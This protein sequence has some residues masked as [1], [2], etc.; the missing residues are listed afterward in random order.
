VRTMGYSSIAVIENLTK[1]DGTRL[2]DKNKLLEYIASNG[3]TYSDGLNFGKTNIYTGKVA[4]VLLIGLSSPDGK[5]RTPILI[6]VDVSKFTS[7]AAIPERMDTFSADPV[8]YSETQPHSSN[9]QK[10]LQQPGINMKYSELTTMNK[11]IDSIRLGG[12]AKADPANGAKPNQANCWTDMDRQYSGATDEKVSK[13][14]EEKGITD[15]AHLFYS[16]AIVDELQARYGY[17]TPDPTR[18]Y[19]PF[20][21]VR[22]SENATPSTNCSYYKILYL[23][24]F[25]ALIH[26]GVISNPS[27]LTKS[28]VSG[29][30]FNNMINSMTRINQDATRIGD[31]DNQSS[32]HYLHRFHST[33]MSRD[34]RLI[35]GQYLYSKDFK[36]KVH[37]RR[38]GELFVWQLPV[39]TLGLDTP[40]YAILSPNSSWAISQ[41]NAIG[42][43]LALQADSNVVI[44]IN[45]NATIEYN[46]TNIPKTT[47]AGGSPIAA[48]GT[49]QN[50][51]M[52]LSDMYNL[53]V[54]PGGVAALLSAGANS[55]KSKSSYVFGSM[56]KNFKYT[57]DQYDTRCVNGWDAYKN[58]SFVDGNNVSI[59][60]KSAPQS[61]CYASPLVRP[62]DVINDVMQFEDA[63]VQLIIADYGN[64]KASYVNAYD[65]YY[66]IMSGDFMTKA[67]GLGY[68]LSNDTYDNVR[69]GYCSR[70]NRFAK[71]LD[72]INNRSRL[73][74]ANKGWANV[75]DYKMRKQICSGSYGSEYTDVCAVIAPK[76]DLILSLTK[77]DPVFGTVGVGKSNKSYNP[78]ETVDI[79][80]TM[81]KYSTYTPDQLDVL[82]TAINPAYYPKWQSLYAA[83]AGVS[84][85][86]KPN[87]AK[88]PNYNVYNMPSVSAC[89]SVFII[90]NTQSGLISMSGEM[91]FP[92]NTSTTTYP[93][94][95][96]FWKKVLASG[97]IYPGSK[98][99]GAT[100]TAT[101]LSDA[102]S[103]FTPADYNLIT[104][105]LYDTISLTI[106]GAPGPAN[107]LLFIKSLSASKL[108][109]YVRSLQTITN[110][111]L[112]SAT[113][114]CR[115]APD[116]CFDNALSY[117]NNNSFDTIS[118]TWC[119][120]ALAPINR[121]T[122]IS[123]LTSSNATQLVA[124]CNVAYAK[125]NCAMPET[126][127][128]SGF[129]GRSVAIYS[130]S[131][132][133]ES[134]SGS[135]NCSTIC[136]TAPIGG[137]LY[138]ACKTGSIQYCQ[139]ESNIVSDMCRADAAIYPEVQTMLTNWCGDKS[140]ALVPAYAKYCPS[141]NASS[142]APSTANAVV[143]PFGSVSSGAL[144]TNMPSG[145]GATIVEIP[146][147]PM[148]ELVTTSAAPVT[149]NAMV[150]PFGSVSSGALPTNMP[151][152][153]GA[154]IV[155][156]PVSPMNELVTTSAPPATTQSI[157]RS[158]SNSMPA[159]VSNSNSMPATV[160]NSTTGTRQYNN[161][162]SA[163]FAGVSTPSDRNNHAITITDIM[164]MILMTIIGVFILGAS[165]KQFRQ[166]SGMHMHKQRR[167]LREIDLLM[168]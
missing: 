107:A 91:D 109:E 154:T 46:G 167:G 163:P 75:I 105:T 130:P 18:P 48:T 147:S 65:V 38:N 16:I 93:A 92:Y 19:S 84:P 44:Y 164:I 112:G 135:S 6:D 23:P 73:A 49:D 11:I 55:G 132:S 144:P 133:F 35:A 1:Q 63:G 41:N 87:F 116:A 36:Y 43:I 40:L 60:N 161:I 138:N 162:G 100:F 119:D 131:K 121:A 120:L 153:S 47:I 125:T 139:R 13:Q 8:N 25:D 52:R 89:P 77:I 122:D 14:Y 113:S 157:S 117:I 56:S 29:I 26:S 104:S 81:I 159:T 103:L 85:F 3:N 83:S 24:E 146:V 12:A 143:V 140:N 51:L 158:N 69:M 28:F 123:Y 57:S 27:L 9:Y 58:G 2:G 127:Y 15:L 94:A 142:A 136:T 80:A 165:I 88:S 31:P 115:L 98:W 4:S 30:L 67:A 137:P 155:E 160:S 33:R 72:C 17:R 95:D 151:S 62:A 68:S 101:T 86:T 110:A 106:T 82:F 42:C 70:G 111:E 66:A 128:K 22:V 134:F 99:S 97:T 118:N 50:A 145:S 156:I 102:K 152:G 114:N 59:T 34:D 5:S 74:S 78:Y 64:D 126:R 108:V 129:K 32:I 10:T 39:T 20:N 76:S 150:V 166:R 54:L 124:A 168:I 79:G 7:T 141:S 71:D 45:P 53:M 61:F 96:L 21:W 37:L 90:M 149:T 148:N